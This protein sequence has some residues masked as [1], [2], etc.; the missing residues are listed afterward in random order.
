MKAYLNKS[1]RH[2]HRDRNFLCPI[3]CA[4]NFQLNFH[5]LNISH[6]PAKSDHFQLQSAQSREHLQHQEIPVGDKRRE[7]L[8]CPSHHHKQFPIFHCWISPLFLLLSS[9]HQP[10]LILKTVRESNFTIYG[11][12]K[13]ARLI[14]LSLSKLKSGPQEINSKEIRPHFTHSV[15]WNNR[16]K[17]WKNSNPFKSDFSLPSPSSMLKL[18]NVE[19]AETSYQMS[20]VLSLCHQDR[21]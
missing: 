9:F 20:K 21:M 6:C 3:L 1:P 11:K 2:L 7:H 19:V 5:F 4:D 14:F 18:T 16:Y 15:N 17:V 12:R 13:Q 10:V 8:L